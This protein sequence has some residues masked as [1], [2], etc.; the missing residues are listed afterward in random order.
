MIIILRIQ[1]FAK[2]PSLAK[3]LK[4]VLTNNNLPKVVILLSLLCNTCI[5]RYVVLLLYFESSNQIH[6]FFTASKE[7]VIERGCLITIKRSIYSVPDPSWIRHYSHANSHLL[8]LNLS[9]IHWWKDWCKA[10][11]A[12]AKRT[13]ASLVDLNWRSLLFRQLTSGDTGKSVSPGKWW[14]TKGRDPGE[15]L[16]S[17][18]RV[19]CYQGCWLC[20]HRYLVHTS[21]RTSRE[22]VI[23]RGCLIDNL[24]K[25]LLSPRSFVVPMVLPCNQSAIKCTVVTRLV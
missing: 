13:L 17:L 10:F 19:D 16:I 18:F 6:K 15:G 4:L 21:V 8:I 25:Y 20:P 12:T 7:I 9:S 14:W 22:S 3:T 24:T 11:L 23:I 1:N 2:I 5:Q